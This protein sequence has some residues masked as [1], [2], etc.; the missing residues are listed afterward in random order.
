M[1][2]LNEKR[3]ETLNVVNKNSYVYKAITELLTNGGKIIR[4]G[5]TT[6]SGRYSK[7]VNHTLAISLKL[8]SIG[9]EHVCKND[10]L[11]GGVNGE[12]IVLKRAISGAK[13]VITIHNIGHRLGL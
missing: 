7:A 5:Y 8:D 2:K 11:R 10:A 3:M 12:H 6:G 9:I 4:T 13:S 1:T